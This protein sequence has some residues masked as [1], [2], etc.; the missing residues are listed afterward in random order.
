MNIVGIIGTNSVPSPTRDLLKFI[1]QQFPELNL[2]LIEIKDLPLFNQ[3]HQVSQSKQLQQLNDRI[4]Q[5][6]GVIIG[7]SEHNH[8]ITASLK[9][10]L[11][12]MSFDLHP[13]QNKPV[14]IVG[15][16]TSALG[17][18]NAQTHL[19]AV[20]DA[21]GVNA[22]VLPG[23]EFL[24]GNADD[25][26]DSQGRLKDRKT[27]DFLTTTIKHFIKF[28]P[29]VEKYGTP[30]EL[31]MKPGTYEVTTTGHNG[32]L[33]M[34]VKVSDHRIEDIDID[35]SGETK[36][37]ADTVFEKLP[38]EIIAGQTLNVDAVTG[39]SITS[40]GVINGVADAVE[41]A[42][43][44][45][46]ILK[47][48]PKAK[49]KPA[50]KLDVE[51]HTDVV[52]VGGGGAGL[53]AAARTLQN[54][55]NA[56]LLEKAPALGGNTVR[57][58]GPMNAADPDWQRTFKALPGEAATLQSVLKQDEQEID[59][60]YRQDFKKLKGQIQDYLDHGDDYLFDS[61][62]WHEI[63]TYLG[64]KRTDLKGHEIHGNYQLVNTLVN[65][66]L[67]SVKWL[68]K[69]GVKFDKSEV[70][71]PVGAKWRRGHKPAGKLGFAYIEALGSFVKENGGQIMLN[72]KASDLIIKDG[73]VIGLHAEGEDRQLTIYARSVILAAGGFGA[74]TKMLQKYNTY[75]S[76]IDDD[77][78]TTNAPTITGDGIKLGQS[79][80]AALVGMGFTQMMPVAE[81]GTGELFSG[82]QVP[83]A[84]FIMVNQQG[85]RFVDEYESRDVLSKA[86]IANGGLFYLIADENIKKTAYNTSQEQ[87]DQQV[88]QGRLF[89]ADT[90]ADLAKQIG[91]DPQVLEETIKKYNSYVDAGKDPEFGK[92]VFDLKVEQAP[93]YATPRKP[94]MH[95]T[96]GGLKID[97]QTH[98][99]NP[100]NQ[101]IKGLYAAGEVAGGIHAGNR[102]GGNSLADIF[103]FGRIA[104]DTAVKE[105]FE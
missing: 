75:W 41:M 83:P 85:K 40:N 59:P 98:V 70:T 72:T 3:D 19:R 53:T 43:G 56:I 14:L 29:A 49:Q 8:T 50:A 63:Q 74:N 94:A 27:V 1:Q 5:A 92:E 97:P 4:T 91:I 32:K 7:T 9:S 104:A 71:M 76:K 73:R 69:L 18:A 25:A 44:E 11:E 10:F 87:I 23:N 96:M 38:R 28:I 12:W 61:N 58:G 65:N 54:H 34:K 86:A 48:R 78:A 68:E 64:G 52:I 42:G 2:E 55:R 16:S 62:L 88:K 46:Q 105:L 36:G 6:D 24:L 15:T 37:I 66:D 26:F 99:I 35:T 95:H 77:I 31:T 30:D 100:D 47:D 22:A 80:G 79:A 84:N 57:S 101:V 90:L 20:L 67:A 103:T 89:R 39:A 13:F 81:P 82:L 45:P 17:S 93:F 102:L 60:E 51:Y 33:P 21:P